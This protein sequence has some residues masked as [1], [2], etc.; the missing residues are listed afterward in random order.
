MSV[1]YGGGVDFILLPA[2]FG[3][4]PVSRQSQVAG[5][6]CYVFP[7]S[8]RL[9]S[10]VQRKGGPGAGVV[11]APPAVDSSFA[12]HRRKVYGKVVS[13]LSRHE[14]PLSDGGRVWGTGAMRGS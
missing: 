8:T 13:C 14:V 7:R 10:C 2:A 3:G 6:F 12:L 1:Q 4:F 5:G 9:W 11:P